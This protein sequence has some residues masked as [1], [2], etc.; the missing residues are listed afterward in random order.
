VEEWRTTAAISEERGPRPSRSAVAAVG[1]LV[2]RAHEPDVAL[3]G[4]LLVAMLDGRGI[5]DEAVEVGLRHVGAG[6]AQAACDRVDHF[7]GRL[8]H[9]C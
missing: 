2:Q 9:H 3:E 7:F 4:T 6:R 5:G 1:E 8:A